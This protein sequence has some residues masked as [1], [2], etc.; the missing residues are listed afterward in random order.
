MKN[1]K[2]CE[3]KIR[4]TQSEKKRIAER[5]NSTGKSISEFTREMLLKGKVVSVPQFTEFQQTGIRLLS[6]NN[7]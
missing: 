2:E 5:A 4:C 7:I 1:K 3:L 6:H